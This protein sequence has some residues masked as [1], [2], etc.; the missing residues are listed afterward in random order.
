MEPLMQLY[1]AEYERLKEEQLRRIGFRDNLIYANIGATGAGFGLGL[2]QNHHNAILLLIPFASAI[3]GWT[4]LTNDEKITQIGSYVRTELTQ[5]MLKELGGTDATLFGW[6]VHHQAIKGRR[7]Q[8]S[9]QF[10]INVAAF[11]GPGL[12]ATLVAVRSA[13]LPGSLLAVGATI[14]LLLIVGLSWEFAS[15]LKDVAATS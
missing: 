14:D 2:S 9:A 5:K 15:A 6:E 4:Y 8:R 11:C 3:L 12:L 7:R 10:G 13:A 1:L